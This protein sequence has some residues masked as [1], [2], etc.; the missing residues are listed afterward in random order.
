MSDEEIKKNEE[1]QNYEEPSLT[2]LEDVSGGT[3]CWF[4]IVDNEG[5]PGE[6]NS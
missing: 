2:D 6:E 5:A 4:G 3:I 1:E